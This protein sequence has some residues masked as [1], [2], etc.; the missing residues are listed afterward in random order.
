MR[1]EEARRP[2][3]GDERRGIDAARQ[4]LQ[5]EAFRPHPLRERRGRKRREIAERRQPPAEEQVE[6]RRGRP[7]AGGGPG[8][9]FTGRIAPFVDE[10]AQGPERQRRQRRGGIARDDHEPGVDGRQQAGGGLRRSDGDANRG[11]VIRRRIG[12]RGANRRRVAEQPA[13]AA[14]VEH[15]AAGAMALDAR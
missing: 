11:R 3:I 5:Q 2:G 15:H 6:P 1:L 8:R 4:P 9:A 13:E 12:E 14:D 10:R 7:G